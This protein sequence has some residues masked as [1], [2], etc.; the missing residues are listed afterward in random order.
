MQSTVAVKNDTF[1]LGYAF[2]FP[3]SG[4]EK[5][6]PKRDITKNKANPATAPS[7]MSL[8]IDSIATILTKPRLC[9]V[10]AGRRAPNK[11]ENRARVATIIGKAYQG[12]V[13][14]PV[15]ATQIKDNAVNWRAM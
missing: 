14:T 5:P 7:P 10:N 9:V 4:G 3:M 1:S 8:S 11:M 2:S 6:I 15:N 12:G 13:E